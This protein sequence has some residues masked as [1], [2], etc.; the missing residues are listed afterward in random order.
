MTYIRRIAIALVFTITLT[1]YASTPEQ[2]QLEALLSERTRPSMSQIVAILGMP[3]KRIE[4]AGDRWLSAAEAVRRNFESQLDTVKDLPRVIAFMEKAFP[5]ATWAPLGRDA[6]IFGDLLDAFYLSIGQPNRVSRLNASTA[7][8]AGASQRDIIRFMKEAGLDL[9]NVRQG[10]PFVCLDRTNYRDVSQSSQLMRAVYSE[11]E[12]SGRK[13]SSL[14]KRVNFIGLSSSA[15]SYQSSLTWLAQYFSSLSVIS[16]RPSSI[17]Q[18]PVGQWTDSQPWHD[19]F[20]AFARQ[21]NG[22]FEGTPGRLMSMDERRQILLEMIEILKRV[23]RPNF[24][25]AVTKEA[26]SLKYD[27]FSTADYEKLLAER[28]KAL[29]E[30]AKNFL[31]ETQN[32]FAKTMAE[33]NQQ[34]LPSEQS[35]YFSNRAILLVEWLDETLQKRAELARVHPDLMKDV[36]ANIVVLHFIAEVTVARRAKAITSKDY[37]RLLARSLSAAIPNEK[38]LEYFE[39]LYRAEPLLRD[40]L[41]TRSE[42]FLTTFN[43]KGRPGTENTEAV[44]LKLKQTVMSQPLNCA[45]VFAFVG[46]P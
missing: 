15:A 22:K 20:G 40:T 28:E 32:G 16:S 18:L 42:F 39:R 17:L 12:A 27:F 33:A 1:V 23:S 5:G 25:D 2:Q 13:A 31:K 3:P 30:Q 10:R 6:V 44:Y 8:F 29:E 38:F 21:P 45:D 35:A 26:R 34:E 37:R 41:Q 19:T 4:L 46:S 43:N 7:S 14:L 9:G 24:L 36:D 11:Y